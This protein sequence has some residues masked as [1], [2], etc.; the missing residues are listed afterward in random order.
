MY[1]YMYIYIYC[2]HMRPTC[3]D[4]GET[5]GQTEKHR[6]GKAAGDLSLR[7]PSE[8]QAAVGD[9]SPQVTTCV[10]VGRPLISR[11]SALSIFNPPKVL[12]RKCR[13]ISLLTS[14]RIDIDPPPHVAPRFCSSASSSLVLPRILPPLGA[15]AG[16]TAHFSIVFRTA[17]CTIPNVL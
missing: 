2:W 11:H 6:I 15:R 8:V 16:N 10:H 7:Y 17:L 12:Q 13:R 4:P 1:M 3:H 9:L 5:V 14:A